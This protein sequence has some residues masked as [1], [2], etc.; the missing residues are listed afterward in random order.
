MPPMAEAMTGRPKAKLSL[1][2]IGVRSPIVGSSNACVAGINL[3]QL[4]V[5][6]QSLIGQTAM[7]PNPRICALWS[8]LSND[9]EFGRDAPRSK[10]GNDVHSKITTLAYPIDTNPGKARRFHV[11]SVCHAYDRVF[12]QI[13]TN[14]HNFKLIACAVVVEATNCL[15]ISPVRANEDL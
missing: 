6:L 14:M 11:F 3:L 8:C 2:A 9:I 5:M 13:C 7:H 15:F 1:I 10:T 4:C 12:R